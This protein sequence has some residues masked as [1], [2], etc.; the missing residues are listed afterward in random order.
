M[1]RLPTLETRFIKLGGLMGSIM[2]IIEPSV[3]LV[4]FSLYEISPQILP[5]TTHKQKD[6]IIPDIKRDKQTKKQKRTY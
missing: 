6:R 1:I 4:I 2:M 5:K 3:L